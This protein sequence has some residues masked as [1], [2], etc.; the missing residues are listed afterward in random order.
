MLRWLFPNG[1]DWGDDVGDFDGAAIERA[2][3][4]LGTLFGPR[5]YFGVEVAGWHH[6]PESPV[7]VVSNHSGGTLFLD[8]W[9]LG[10]AWYTHFGSDR[11]IHPAVHEMLLSNPWT[12]RFFATRGAVRADGA[13][14]RRV[15]EQWRDDLLVM[16]GGDLDVWRPYS[17]RFEVQFAGRTGYARIALLAGVPVVPVANAGAHET[18]VVLTDGQRLAT[19]FGLPKIARAHVF[20]VHL[21]LP[22]GLGVGPWPHLPLPTTLRYRFGRPV[23]P[24]EVGVRAGEPPTDAQIAAFDEKVRAGVQAQLDHLRNE[25]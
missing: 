16:P 14:A 1:A 5:R 4:W 3:R 18:F 9:G 22:W 25:R 7:M 8:S 20:P 6:L 12:G 2:R 17:K 10:W 15:L 24:H 21:S 19:F 23:Y 11:P 13:V